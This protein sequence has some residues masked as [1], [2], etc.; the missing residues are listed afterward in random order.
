MKTTVIA[1]VIALALNLAVPATAAAQQLPA[2][3]PALATLDE[4]LVE[5][6]ALRAELNETANA[7]LRAQLL[8]ARLALQEQRITVVGK[9]LADVQEKLRAVE[10][11]RP[12][13]NMLK[14]MGA[15]KEAPDT[16]V[17]QEAN[18]FLDHLRPGRTTG[19]E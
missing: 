2:R 5:L 11:H 4:V 13:A 18:F 9:E 14:S 1:P 3:T 7:S 15:Q 16:D 12:I 19:K 6:R 17:P 10:Q 8:V